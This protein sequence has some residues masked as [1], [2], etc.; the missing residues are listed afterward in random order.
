MVFGDFGGVVSED[1]VVLQGPLEGLAHHV[2]DGDDE[3]VLL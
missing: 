1:E 3:V 2:F